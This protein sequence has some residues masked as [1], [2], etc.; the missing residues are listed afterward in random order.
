MKHFFLILF[1]LTWRA[2]LVLIAFVGFI[3]LLIALE[4]KMYIKSTTLELNDA[5]T[6][7][8]LG[9]AVFKDGTM[10]TLFKDRVDTALM[11]YK[12]K[13]VK[14][15]LV[16]GDNGTLTHN[17]VNPARNYLLSQG[18]PSEDIFL[19]HAGFDT[20]SSMYR[21]RDIFLVY[22]AIIVTQSFHLPRAVFIARNLG[23]DAYGIP[24]DQHTYLFKNYVR[25]IFADIK[26]VFNVLYHRKPKYLGDQIPVTGDSSESI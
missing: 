22:S 12:E 13:K 17:E 9:A 4:S 23:M 21:A 26:A 1:Q 18:V 14:N 20:Y 2:L 16:T 25:E 6:A 19:D 15:I 10:T 5:H 3:F 11:L 24:S 8:V 7:I